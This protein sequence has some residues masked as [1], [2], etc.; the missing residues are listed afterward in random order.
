MLIAALGSSFA[1]GPTLEPVADRAAM[2]S[3]INYPSRLATALGADLI[4][5]TV[6]GATV[7]TILEVPQVIAPGVQF[8]PQIDGLPATADLVTITSGG[9]D[10]RYIGSMLAT[11]WRRYDPGARMTAMLGPQ[12]PGI[13]AADAETTEALTGLLA[14]VVAAVRRRAPRARIVLVDYLTVLGPGSRSSVVD[15]A[16]AELAA[17]RALQDALERAFRNAA[18]RS[19][20]ELVAVSEL[21]RDHAVGS[22]VPW[23]ED[24]VPDPRRTVGSFH[25]TLAGMAA[26]AELL[27][28]GLR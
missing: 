25:P 2:R 6:S 19:G 17:F 16:P 7:G 18:A 21:S 11:A 15:F 5:L 8:P 22:A 3:A 12:Y 10:V 23:V 14:R 27:V 26:V 20:A 13:P 9:N 28:T 1:A 24:F 4:D